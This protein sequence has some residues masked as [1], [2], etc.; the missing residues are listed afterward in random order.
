MTFRFPNVTLEFERLASG[1]R[2][3]LAYDLIVPSTAKLPSLARLYSEKYRLRDLLAAWNDGV[4]KDQGK[5]RRS[6]PTLLVYVCDSR[7]DASQTINLSTLQYNDQVRATC[8]KDLCPQFGM[9]LYIADLDRELSGLCDNGD[10]DSYVFGDVNEDRITLSQL[11]D[12]DGRTVADCKSTEIEEPEHFIQNEPF[13]DDPDEQDRDQFGYV[14]HIYRRTVSTGSEFTVS[15]ADSFK[16]LGLDTARGQ[17]TVA[18][19]GE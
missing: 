15:Q 5:Q 17:S 8:L 16:G 10:P 11:D 1:Y 4:E 9:G 13:C 18:Y 12:I 2:L 6:F 14:T 7:Y 3:I 19:R